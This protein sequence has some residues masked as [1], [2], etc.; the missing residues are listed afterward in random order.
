MEY[1]DELQ[2]QAQEKGKFECRYTC[3]VKPFLEVKEYD[4]ARG[5]PRREGYHTTNLKFIR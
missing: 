5:L 1:P 3:W 4:E 2:A